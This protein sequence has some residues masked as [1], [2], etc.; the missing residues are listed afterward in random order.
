VVKLS[1]V[2]TDAAFTAKYAYTSGPN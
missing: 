1:G 2:V